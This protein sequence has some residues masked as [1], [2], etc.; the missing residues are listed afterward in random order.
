MKRLIENIK[1]ML[2]GRKDGKSNLPSKYEEKSPYLK[3]IMEE[4]NSTINSV[5]GQWL[6][7]DESLKSEWLKSTG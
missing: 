3:K 7:A 4:G 1:A 6:K 5:N 2:N